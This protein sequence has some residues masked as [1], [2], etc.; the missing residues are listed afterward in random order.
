MRSQVLNP[1]RVMPLV[2]A[3][4][5]AATLMA[6]PAAA[7]A[8]PRQPD[9]PVVTGGLPLVNTSEKIGP[10]IGL[11]HVKAL[12]QSGWYDAQFLTVDLSNSA[13]S[14]D[15]LTAGPVASGGP[16]SVAANK[17]SAVAGVNGEFFDI[18]NS[19][20]ALGGEIQNGQL[21]KT[22]DIG[23]R[24]HVG[25]SQDGIAQLV[26]LA[27]DSN[28]NFAGADHKVLSI[29]AAN[30]GG[31]PVDGL[32][33]FTAGWGTYSRNRGFTGVDVSR[34]AEVV[35]SGGKVVAVAPTGPAG[36]G[37]IP[38][39][40]FALVGRDAAATALRALQPGDPVTLTYAPSNDVTKTMKFALGNGGTIV[41]GGKVAPGLDTAI[42][43]RTALGFKDGGRTLVLAT[44]D[45]PGGTGKGG[46]GID[47]EARDLAALGVETA[48]NLDGGGS[49]TMVAR[50]LGTTEATVRNVPSDGHERNDPNGVGVFVTPG[51]GKLHQL[52][53]KPAAG[54]TSSDGGAKVFPGLRRTLVAQGLDDHETPVAVKP[55]SVRWHAGGASVKSGVLQAPSRA[56]GSI[57]VTAAVGRTD[58]SAK[59]EVLGKL[60]SVELSAGRLSIADVT[61]DAAATVGVTGRDDQGYTAPIDPT[62]LT[63]DYDHSVVDVQ[64]SAGKL[65]ITPLKAAG[66]ILT[67][68]VA[69][70]SAQLPITVGVQTVSAYDFNDDV[71]ARW[72]NNSTAAT[73]FAK[74]PDGLR[75]DFAAMRNVGIAAT[76]VANRVAVPGQPLRVRVR[77][78]SS[79]AVPNG[80][81]YLGYSDANGKGSGVYGTALVASDDWQYATFT[82]PANTAFPI[83]ISGFQGINTSVPQQ[84]AGTFLLNRIEADVPSSIDLPEQPELQPDRLVSPDGSL[85]RGFGTWTFASL[86]DVQFTADN[87]NLTQVATAALQRIRQTNPDLVILNGD[88]T[89][90]G[91]PQDLALA[92]QVLT[93]AGC[94]L[95]PV[96]QEP[97]E[98]ST[99]GPRTG[100]VPC[101]YVPGNHESYGLNNTQSDLSA[102]KA[103]FGQP[104]RT[105]DH[106]GTRFILLASSLGTLRG[107]AWDQLPMMQKALDDAKRDPS[108]RNVVVAAHHPVDDPA[109]TKAS[110]LGDRDEAALVEK[111]L[112]DFRDSSRKGAVMFGSHAQ[113]ANVHRVDGVPYVVLPSS[114]KDPYGTPDRG[115][116]TGWVNWSVNSLR[117]AEQQWLEA[118]VRAFAQSITLNAPEALEVDKTAQLSGSIVQPQ[119]VSTGSRVVPLRYPMSVHWSGSSSLAIGTGAEAVAG[120][121][122][123]GKVAILDPQTRTLTALR[124]GSVTVTVT[125]DSMRQYTDSASLAPITTSKTIQVGPPAPAG[126]K[127][128]AE[129]PVFT[130]QPVGTFGQVRKITVTNAGDQPLRIFSTDIEAASPDLRDT[131]DRDRDIFRIDRDQCSGRSIAPGGTCVVS[132]RFTPK[133]PDVTST[134]SLAFRTNT[135]E[136]RASVTLT[137]TSTKPQWSWGSDGP[138]WYPSLTGLPWSD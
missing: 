56:S 44:W 65:K 89:D 51:D 33:A 85:E 38:Q 8:H 82:L 53:V 126:P 120:A 136:R 66:T 73:T 123:A 70:K 108:V 124:R 88:I 133:Q 80:L 67:I 25:V 45:G 113:I 16:L 77:I 99:P 105:F 69:G 52:L 29:N 13:V 62:D 86:S 102:F 118:D 20:A 93:D 84:R 78:K 95:I 128:S 43:P 27:V 106:K 96:G 10:G 34:I 98:Y 39:D 125:N 3:L 63:L 137:G 97:A 114:G 49:T 35:V 21:L 107:T 48:V 68:S 115:G 138:A 17:A 131:F 109:E 132:V 111:L 104:Y 83:A 129:T 74:D 75:I 55:E 1:R 37:A 127:F 19:N 22:A 2:G 36:A 57:S 42:A 90:R 58:A 121:R 119:G 26:D 100:K 50:A 76:S 40:G 5:A 60:D 103:E 94:D 92:R 130:A 41:S 23:G 110:Q 54:A 112:T 7:E 72:R 9:A 71:L 31:V 30:G 79:I 6:F 117:N 47:K 15:L 134:A 81:T 61:P 24:Q 87:P 64:P 91:L 4:A 28:A 59:I 135:A 32:V 46:V 11:Q 14:T 122:R 18:G 101:Y 12:D 116:F